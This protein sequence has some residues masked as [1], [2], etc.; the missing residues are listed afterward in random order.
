[1]TAYRLTR[2]RRQFVDILSAADAPLS[3]YEIMDRF[4]ARFGAR[5][6]A[7]SAY[8][9]LNSLIEAGYVHRLETC[10]KYI[11]C[12][13]EPEHCCDDNAPQFFIC[14]RCEAVQE[15]HIPSAL[16]GAL[17]NS[18]AEHGF[19]VNYPQIE[20]HGTCRDCTAG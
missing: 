8:R 5:I 18:V 19:E 17:N 11:A 13:H 15:L 3:A 7:P 12:A 4:N 16:L 9:I 1:M 20:L 10:N 14:D 6:L 2:K